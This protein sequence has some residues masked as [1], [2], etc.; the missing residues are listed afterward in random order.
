MRYLML[1]PIALLLL[2]LAAFPQSAAPIPHPSQADPDTQAIQ[3]IEEDFIKAENTT[4][5]AVLE[6]TLADDYVNLTP[7][8]FGPGKA[9]IIQG[10]QP[11]A[12][13]A[14][15]YSVEMSDM[16]IYIL[17]ETAIAAYTR[18][19]TAKENGNVAKEDTT[20]VFVRDQG[21]WKLKISRTSIRGGE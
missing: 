5:V 10:M 2:S 1:A 9:A 8:G 14:P 20:H 19:Y 12:G 21:T 13:H 7:R 18:T 17:G 3:K 11:H 15:R 4:D 6:R 16:H